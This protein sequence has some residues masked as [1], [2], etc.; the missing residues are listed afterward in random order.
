[1][2]EYIAIASAH[3]VGFLYL[4]QV[5][6]TIIL[7]EHLHHLIGEELLMVGGMVGNDDIS[8][9]TFLHQDEYA[10]VDHRILLAL[11]SI[12]DLYG[13]LGLD[14]L[15]YVY[16]QGINGKHGIESHHGILL[17][18]NT[19]VIRCYVDGSVLERAT[20][21]GPVASSRRK[22]Y[23]VVRSKVLSYVSVFISFYLLSG[24]SYSREGAEGLVAMSI[25]HGT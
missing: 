8:L 17:V 9:G 5:Q 24:E 11:E 4:V 3:E 20:E 15:R 1:M 7:A 10:S 6:M 19:I 12:V 18:G 14:T 23:A 25:H 13:V 16:E 21:F 2:D 22:L